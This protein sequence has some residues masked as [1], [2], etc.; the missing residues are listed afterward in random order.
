MILCA[1]CAAKFDRDMI[2][3][4]D[5]DRSITAWPTPKDKRESLRD[6]IIKQYGGPLELIANE[7][8]IFKVSCTLAVITHDATCRKKK[9]ESEVEIC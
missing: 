2:R 3:L 4:R 1:E 6:A 9:K 5:W 8:P 7:G